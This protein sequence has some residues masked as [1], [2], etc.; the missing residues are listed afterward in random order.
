MYLG[1]FTLHLSLHKAKWVQLNGKTLQVLKTSLI[2]S[3]YIMSKLTYLCLKSVSKNSKDHL[4]LS[5]SLVLSQLPELPNFGD[6]KAPPAPPLTTALCCTEYFCNRAKLSYFWGIHE[7][8][9]YK[10]IISVHCSVHTKKLISLQLR[11][12]KILAKKVYFWG[13]N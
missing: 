12:L 7:Q 4:F 10:I 3:A 5:D 13:Q 6:A 8:N 11:K 9:K 2:Q 1:S